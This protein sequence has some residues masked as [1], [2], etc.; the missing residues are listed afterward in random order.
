[1]KIYSAWSNIWIPDELRCYIIVSE[2]IFLS[3]L[4][5]FQSRLVFR[6]QHLLSKGCDYSKCINLE[7]NSLNN[8]SSLNHIQ[9]GNAYLYKQSRNCADRWRTLL[10]FVQITDYPVSCNNMVSCTHNDFIQWKH[11]PRYWSLVQGIHRSTLNSP[12][13]GQL[14][15][16]LMLSLIYAWING[17][18]NNCE[19]SDLRR[20]RT[21]Y[22]V[23]VMLRRN[24]RMSL[25]LFAITL[26]N[27][28]WCHLDSN[29]AELTKG[30]QTVQW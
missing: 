14:R 21:H 27:S 30:M 23:T 11:F 25:I 3:W 1:M 12:H 5:L 26:K 13:K 2:N 22:D 20:Y 24:F 16:A 10:H 17:W 19:A 8:N 9:L 28:F 18:V 15:G 6:Y 4:C 29:L 7:W